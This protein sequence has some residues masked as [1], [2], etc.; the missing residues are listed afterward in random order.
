MVG[1]GWVQEEGTHGLGGLLDAVGEGLGG[2]GGRGEGAGGAGPEGR[3]SS[4][5][6]HGVLCCGGWGVVLGEVGAGCLVL[7]ECCWGKRKNSMRL[8]TVALP[9]LRKS[10][11][12]HLR[13]RE[14]T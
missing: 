5:E 1:G 10:R 13:R 4:D 9:L 8:Y 3:E 11:R 14:M 12:A 2:H 7:I 6:G